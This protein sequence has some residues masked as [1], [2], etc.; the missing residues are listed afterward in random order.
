MAN[1]FLDTTVLVNVL[2]KPS[3]DGKKNQLAVS[4]FA[5]AETPTYA[6]K[7]MHLGALRAWVWFHNACKT[8]GTFS[9]VSDRLHGLSRSQQRNL[10]SS[11]LEAMREA[12][13]ANTVILR[14]RT[15]A[16]QDR[17]MADMYR[18]SV[19]G[20]IL[21]A[22]HRRRR[23]ASVTFPLTCYLEEGP[24]EDYG[25]MLRLGNACPKVPGDCSLAAY[26]RSRL[27]EV[28]KLRD[29]ILLLKSD[30]QEDQKRTRAL[31]EFLRRPA[32]PISETNCRHLGDAV[33]ALLCPA[34]SVVLTTNLRD[35][36][37]LTTALG[38]KAEEV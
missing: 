22:W 30:R 34:G 7:E 1:A 14:S 11:A 13:R 4:A 21:R 28:A 23:V 38:K 20:L 19:K 2:L 12:T 9:R 10:H 16:Q 5:K 25:G 18:L 24:F 3:Q 17:D 35:H 32:L 36:V 29:A 31:K 27:P 6:L 33:F 37:P 26:M 8:E 15:P